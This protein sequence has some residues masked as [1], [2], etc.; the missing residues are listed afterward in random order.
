MKTTT[1][2]DAVDLLHKAI[3]IEGN[4]KISEF[5]RGAINQDKTINAIDNSNNWL[6]RVY[7]EGIKTGL[8]ETKY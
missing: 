5:R 8:V 4:N 2:Q 3:T 6:G 7:L 1:E